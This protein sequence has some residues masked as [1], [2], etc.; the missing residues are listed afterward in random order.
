MIQQHEEVLEAQRVRSLVGLAGF[1]S[2]KNRRRAG[3]WARSGAQPDRHD[4]QGPAH[5]VKPDSAVITADGV[6]GRVIHSSNFFSIVQLIIDSQSAVGVM[7]RIHASSGNR[8]G[9]RRR[10][11]WIWTTLTTTTT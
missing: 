2:R 8:E 4:R 10:A 6:V 1:R 5:G 9:H 7:V 3:D 11:I